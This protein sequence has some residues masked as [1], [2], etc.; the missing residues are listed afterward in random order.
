[1]PRAV[2]RRQDDRGLGILGHGL[3][4]IL[5]ERAFAGGGALQAVQGHGHLGAEPGLHIFLELHA[6]QLVERL[7]E[8]RAILLDEQLRVGGLQPLHALDRAQVGRERDV[9]LCIVADQLGD[10]ALALKECPSKNQGEAGSDR[11]DQQGA[12]AGVEP[13]A[14][15]LRRRWWR[16]RRW[17]IGLLEP[18]GR[19]IRRRRGLLRIAHWVRLLV[20]VRWFAARGDDVLV[21]ASE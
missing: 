18:G 11:D 1:M 5:A 12:D 16:W 4:R 17:Q 3:G 14:P 8:A 10:L 20:L 2:A 6:H 15:A 7:V 13:A 9:D 21:A 19:V